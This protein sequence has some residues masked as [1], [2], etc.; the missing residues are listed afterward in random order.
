MLK[1]LMRTLLILL[2]AGLISGALYWAVNG[3]SAQA[4]LGAFGGRGGRSAFG[5]VAG[6]GNFDRPGSF[7]SIFQPGLRGRDFRG[8]DA[9]QTLALTDILIK[10]GLIGLL[11]LVVVGLQRAIASFIKSRKSAKAAGGSS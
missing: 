2:A 10:L 1:I 4:A 5:A 8:G 3:S 7:L 9:A 6:L 11:T